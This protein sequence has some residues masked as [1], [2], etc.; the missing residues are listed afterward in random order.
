[1]G[2]SF[3]DPGLAPSRPRPRVVSVS[4]LT[5]DLKSAVESV[6]FNCHV[7]G[8]V[9]GL[10]IAGKGHWYF[11][12]KDQW[13]QL[14]CVVWATTA[15][16]LPFRLKE[17]MR[18]VAHGDV[19]LYPKSGRYQL[20]IHRLSESGQGEHLL[21]LEK[22]KR[23]LAAEGLF[24]PSHKRPLPAFPAR[25]GVVTASGSAALRDIIATIGRR[26]PRP[27][28][29]A[30][31][32]VQGTDAVSTIV[33]AL[34]N[35][36]D[37]P[38]NAGPPVDVIIVGRGGGSAEDLQAFNDERV[39]RAIAACRVPVVSAVGHEVDLL[40]SDLAADVR[41]ATPTAAAELVVPDRGPSRRRLADARS[42]LLRA[43]QRVVTD[44][45]VAL[46]DLLARTTRGLQSQT[47]ARSQRARELSAR[48]S[49]LHP[50]ARISREQERLKGLVE[51]MDAAMAWETR[52]RR[53]RL[54]NL[55]RTLGALSPRGS[56]DRGYAIVRIGDEKQVLSAS[57]DANIGDRIEVMLHSGTV[58]ATVTDV[59]HS[60]KD[61]GSR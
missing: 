34:N 39:V 30:P 22:L 4:Q 6:F 48:L 29:V 33:A 17:G 28:L 59:H 1:M 32:R 47:R 23:R 8:E 49:N 57:T 21:A 40:L 56:L 3:R 42:R 50:R 19:Q 54:A 10:K 18:V 20:V 11:A 46:D 15:S 36:Q 12:M 9:V 5:N 13:S 26:F 51:R 25:I 53:Q 60:E 61:P 37:L 2:G 31:C 55:E 52:R 14:S 45:Q 27:I 44:R 24:D 38:A 58:W 41:A 7:E 16:R 35:L 43:G